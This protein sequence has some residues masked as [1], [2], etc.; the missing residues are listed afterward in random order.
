MTAAVLA[1]RIEEGAEAVR[2]RFVRVDSGELRDSVT[3][4][5]E[6]DGD[7]A[8]L[9]TNGVRHAIRNELDEALPVRNPGPTGERGSHM[10]ERGINE[11]G[12]GLP[13][14]VAEA[15]RALFGQ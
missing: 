9:R 15:T 14:A 10:I 5:V 4:T 2:E 6:P 3:G 13:E 11:A 8:V 12:D 7:T 1:N